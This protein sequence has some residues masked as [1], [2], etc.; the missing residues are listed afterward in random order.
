M[1]TTEITAEELDRAREALLN[2]IVFSFETRARLMARQLA[3][4]FSG[5]PKD[6]LP[7]YQKALQAVTRGDVQRVAHQYIVPANLAVVAVAN[8]QMLGEPMEKLAAGS[9]V[10][11][12]DLTIPAARAEAAQTTDTSLAEGKLLLQ[13]AQKAAGGVEKLAAIKDCTTISQYQIDPAIP[14]VGGSRI[15]ETDLWMAPTT[16]RQDSTLPSGRVAAYT[17]GRVGWIVNPRGWGAL[18]GT[19]QKQ[20]FGDLFRSWFRI[21]LSDRIE[22]RSVNAVDT[23]AVQITDTTGQEA[24]IEF[25]PA[26]GLPRRVTYDTPQAVGAPLYT[27]DVFEEFRDVDGIKLP[28]R[29]TINQSGKKFAEVTVSEYKL[30]SGLKASEL[31]RRP[32]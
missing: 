12:I 13:R 8:P 27:E 10:N 3:Y 28:S 24:K 31:A 30:N 21:L 9:V 5:Y 20:V 26:T 2:S 19:Q 32:L 22:G 18:V 15:V 29:I 23:H 16:F 7:Q 4:E 6:Y 11:A 25:D 17:D 14:N 1:R